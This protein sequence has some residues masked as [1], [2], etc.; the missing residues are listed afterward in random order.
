MIGGRH[1]RQNNTEASV[2]IF[3]F[4]IESTALNAL[5]CIPGF[6]RN[7]EGS[8]LLQYDQTVPS[9]MRIGGWTSVHPPRAKNQFSSRQGYQKIPMHL[10]M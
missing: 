9:R 10:T 6:V 5:T 4:K 1:S 8:A 7:A 3:K 2:T